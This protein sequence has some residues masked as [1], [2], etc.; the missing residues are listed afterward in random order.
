MSDTMITIAIF[1]GGAL[2]VGA[3]FALDELAAVVG[4]QPKSNQWQIAPI[5]RIEDPAP[6]EVRK[7]GL[8]FKPAGKDTAPGKTPQGAPYRYS[9]TLSGLPAASD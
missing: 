3:V 5:S 4:L 7:T 9:P 2:L 8:V 6:D 1:L